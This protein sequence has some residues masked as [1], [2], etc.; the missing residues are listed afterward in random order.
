MRAFVRPEQVPDVSRA[1]AHVFRDYG[2]REKR[3]RARL[4]FL[5]QDMGWQ[6]V[7][8]RIEE[9]LGYRLEHDESL[10]HPPATHS[11]HMGV[12][13]QKDGNFYV[14]V[15]IERGRLTARNLFDLAKLA[16]K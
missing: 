4:K 9:D 6:W 11:D 16:E 3:N 2:Y 10:L 13:E 8:D 14:G 12:G 7:R 1:V 5:V 15:P